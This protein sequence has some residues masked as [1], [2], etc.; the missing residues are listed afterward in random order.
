MKI[1]KVIIRGEMPEKCMDCALMNGNS[2]K[3]CNI[4]NRLIDDWDVRPEWCPLEY[5]TDL[6][7]E[8]KNL[9]FRLEIA[10]NTLQ[11]FRNILDGV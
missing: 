11:G 8:N 1:E 6:D 2:Y 10:N 9:R 5:W 4:Y 7:A 3:S